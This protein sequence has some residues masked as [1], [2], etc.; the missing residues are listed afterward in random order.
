MP[1][2]SP[3]GSGDFKSDGTVAMTGALQ[4]NGVLLGSSN[5]LEQRNGTNA[6]SNRIY[7]TF[8]DASNYEAL[9]LRWASNVAELAVIA[10]GTGVDR[11]MYVRKPYNTAGSWEFG[12]QWFRYIVSAGPSYG[13]YLLGD[14]G[15]SHSEI[16][17][18][19]GGSLQWGSS[20]TTH[21]GSMDTRLYRGASGRVDVCTTN[22]S[23]YGD[24]KQIGRAHV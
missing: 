23:T 11:N 20:A 22:S 17:F 13:L 5:L 12:P 14:N 10:A 9:S 21:T 24:V 19:S 8:T 7:N 1:L 4:T 2:S 18:G 6:Q 16:R 15:S 3:A